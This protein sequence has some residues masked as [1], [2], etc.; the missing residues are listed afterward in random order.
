MFS[1]R[2]GQL[3]G[4]LRQPAV[5][6]GEQFPRHLGTYPGPFAAGNRPVSGQACR[7]IERGDPLSNLNPKRGDVVAVNLE[8][9]AQAGYR[10]IVPVAEIGALQLL[11]PLLGERMEADTEQ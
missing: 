10:F 1:D 9:R 4:I 5:L 3:P 8:R 2:S 7:R 11:L 6:G